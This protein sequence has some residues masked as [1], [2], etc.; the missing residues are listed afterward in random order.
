MPAVLT[1]QV[2]KLMLIY[3]ANPG[4]D[5]KRITMERHWNNH[6]YPLLRRLVSVAMKKADQTS[7]R[8]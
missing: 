1:F 2:A 5:V 8:V 3:H 4:N 7:P 6:K